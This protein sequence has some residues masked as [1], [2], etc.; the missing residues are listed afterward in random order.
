MEERKFI[1]I[2][3]QS[4]VTAAASSVTKDCEDQEG[5]NGIVLTWNRGITTQSHD[6]LADESV[7]V[8]QVDVGGSGS[9]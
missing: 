6:Q 4:P 1:V 2:R 5:T 7:K 8:D 3:T 9:E